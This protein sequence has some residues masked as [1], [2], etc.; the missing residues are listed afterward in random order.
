MA[1]V[2]IINLSRGELTS[3]DRYCEDVPLPWLEAFRVDVQGPEADEAGDNLRRNN[4]SATLVRCNSTRRA[5]TSAINQN[6]VMRSVVA[7]G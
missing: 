1:P 2:I 3:S 7:Y 4:S 6:W 5:L